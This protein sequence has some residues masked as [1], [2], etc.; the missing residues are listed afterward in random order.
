MARKTKKVGVVARY[1]SRYGRGVRDKAK[2]VIE[3]QKKRYP[4]PSCQSI[5]VKR[6][7]AGIWRCKH[8]GE[9]FAGG[10][11]T[12]GVTSFASREGTENV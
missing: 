5:A 2:T 6:V 10:A 8:C 4:C 12:P 9:T 1:G 7:S 3:K 11:Y